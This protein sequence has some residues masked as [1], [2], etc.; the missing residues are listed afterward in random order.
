MAIGFAGCVRE[1]L[2]RAK[3]GPFGTLISDGRAAT[4]AYRISQAQE[5]VWTR[6]SQVLASFL[7]APGIPPDSTYMM[8]AEYDLPGHL[9][10]CDVVLL[11]ADRWGHKHGCVFE[12]KRW[13]AFEP[14][15]LP[16]YVRVSSVLHLHPAHQA[17]QYRDSIELFHSVGRQYIWHAGAWMTAMTEER[18]RNLGEIGPPD[19]PVWAIRRH[20]PVR[21]QELAKW[22]S[23]GLS[24]RDFHAFRSG[25]CVA[26]ARFAEELLNR[27]PDL[28]R[29]VAKATGSRPIDLSPRQEEVVA[30]ILRETRRNERSLV[31]VSGAPGCGK[32][33]VGLNALA[34]QVAQ[35]VDHATGKGRG[36]SVLALRNSRL[37]TVVR[38]A[39]DEAVR[40]KVGKSLVQYIKGGG[41]G[42][43]IVHEV[44]RTVA[45]G[46]PDPP[47]DL[48]VIDEAHRVPDDIKAGAARLSQMTGVLMAGRTV[49]CLL[50]ELQILNGDDNGTAEKFKKAW[51]A[52]TG[53]ER[54]VELT[55]GE[56]HR[57]PPE[58]AD[59]LDA[60][61]A[62]ERR[63]V[64]HSYEF[65]V[66]RE[67]QSVVDVLRDR[68]SRGGCG[69]LASYTVCN[70]R[71]SGRDPIRDI[72][73]DLRVASLGVRWLMEK[74]EYDVWW[75]DQETRHRFDRC[76]SVYGCQGFE[77]D[78]AGLFWG[79]DLQLSESGDRIEFDLCRPHDVR[80]DIRL[81]YGKPLATLATEAERGDE[82]IRQIVVERLKNRYR[83][84]LSRARKGLVI[85]CED[86]GT[87]K[88]LESLVTVSSED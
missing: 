83:V 65:I 8:L 53:S 42:I 78:Y 44:E 9:G 61:L 13:E 84:L 81:A 29:G 4:G 38:S 21:H 43:G 87:R 31:L 56:Q 19:A 62:G 88:V 33:V 77:L 17:L 16:E 30:A 18:A 60:F 48:V 26:D 1:F 51:Q 70:G 15:A 64:P 67:P 58:Y 40:R 85:H 52:C 2:S 73:Q 34:H 49:V 5:D 20:D 86:P 57:L 11:G 59:W 36:R 41:P 45:S 39:I 79:R 35:S 32:T 68:A 7:A 80:D 75:R 74:E 63:R 10:R 71:K 27:L 3:Q 72:R 22:L 14:S 46:S 55:L 28:T 69:L 6:D 24:E 25:A 54:V 12:L 23:G 76:A 47:Y 50:D 37:C 66:A 82:S